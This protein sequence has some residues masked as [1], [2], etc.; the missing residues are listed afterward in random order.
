LNA[1]A[2]DEPVVIEV[3]DFETDKVE[4]VEWKW[5]AWQIPIIGR[6][7]AAVYDRF[8]SGETEGLV[9]FAEALKR[10]EQLEGMLKE[11]DADRS[12]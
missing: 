1:S 8:A 5:H 9:T 11:W 10:H 3:H 6:S 4:E 2:Y 7:I 12:Q